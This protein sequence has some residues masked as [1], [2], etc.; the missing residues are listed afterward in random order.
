MSS[1][2]S[3]PHRRKY[4]NAMCSLR[5]GASCKGSKDQ[6]S[7]AYS[8]SNRANSRQGRRLQGWRCK[9]VKVGK[10]ESLRLACDLPRM[11]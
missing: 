4:K 3:K 5:Q 7:S 11:H 2:V 6:A 9:H 8:D 10:C 1:F